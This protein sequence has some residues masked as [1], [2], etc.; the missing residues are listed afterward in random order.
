MNNKITYKMNEKSSAIVYLKVGSIDIYDTKIISEEFAKH[1]SS[2]GSRYASKITNPNNTF[3][4]YIKNIPSNP[5]SMFMTPTSK[6]EIERIIEKLPKKTSKG[7]DDISNILLK[8][9]KLL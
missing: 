4:Q 1:F 6:I 5:S 3:T 2:V 9:L 7:H 8:I